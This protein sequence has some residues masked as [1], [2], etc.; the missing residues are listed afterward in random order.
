LEQKQ[1]LPKEEGAELVIIQTQLDQM[2]LDI[3]KCAII[4]IKLFFLFLKKIKFKINSLT[5]LNINGHCLDRK[6]IHLLKPFKFIF[7]P[8]YCTHSTPY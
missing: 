7:S 5:V 6:K 3:A 1:N 2:Y 8:H 4:F